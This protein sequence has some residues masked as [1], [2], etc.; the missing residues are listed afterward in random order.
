[1]D[2]VAADPDDPETGAR[3]DAALLQEATARFKQAEEAH[4]DDFEEARTIQEFVAL[5]QWPQAIKTERESMKRPC[6]T[7]DHQNQYVRHVVNTGL[8]G[9]RDIRVLALSGEADEKVGEILAG[10]VRQ[11]TQ[12][13]SSR[14]AYET[15]LRHECQFGYGY[16]QVKVVEVPKSTLREITIRKVRD[17]R[18][19][20]MDPFCDYPDGRDAKFQ[21]LLTKLTQAEL[22]AQYGPAAEGE[23][24]GSWHE[25]D[26]AQV[27][28]WLGEDGI[29]VAEYYYRETDGTV[30]FAVLSPDRVLQRGVHH[31]DVMPIVRCVGDE[32][33]LEGKARLR[34]LIN[35]SSMDAGRAYNYAS[36]AFIEAVALAPLAPIIAEEGQVEPYITEWKDAHRVP[37]AVLRYKG[38]SL[39]GQVLPPPQR[40]QP[41]GIPEG[42][43]GMMTNL[44][45][46]MQQIMGI[47]QPSVMGTGGA[48][49]QS[50]AGVNAQQEPGEINSF[51]F[52]EHWHTAI[53]QTGRIILA[54][55]P[56]VYTTAQAVKIVGDDLVPTTAILN[57]EQQQTMVESRDAY[58]KVLSSSYNV[59]IGR[60]D[61]AVTTG[62]SSASK[63]MEAN[64]LLMTVVNAFPEMMKVAGDLVVGSMDMAGA[65]VLAKR[66]KALLPPGTT[67]EETGQ[68]L[69]IQQLQEENA[70][71]KQGATEL[72][73]AVMA[74]REKS[75][76]DLMRAREQAQMEAQEH[77]LQQ[78]AEAFRQHLDDQSAVQ[79]ATIKS[80]TDLEIAAQSN[81]V[82]VMV[83]KIAAGSKIDVE[84]MKAFSAA[85]QAERHEDRMGGYLSSMNALTTDPSPT[86]EQEPLHV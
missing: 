73:Q 7:L 41:A 32:Y 75:Q 66:L 43:Q 21:F 44:I 83:A 49:V 79:L 76:A 82:K 1:M 60:Y 14:V 13:S 69:L 81:V 34:G 50:G 30:K 42:W 8:R 24:T 84:I 59:N 16:W 28:P 10:M 36:S 12:V 15:G 53:E 70:Q 40:A 72:Q 47:G 27:L 17:P 31:G 63:K 29:I 4:R 6:L 3:T 86:H 19:V 26:T 18:M 39:S 20:L 65:D 37:R 56:H 85:S 58:G 80:Q 64:K 38:V 46:D 77:E 78:R 45:G 35:K 74:E 55:I 57:P 23:Q 2:D 22:E 54:M 51:H 62:P 67:D 48:P 61:V 11:I 5:D 68:M 33:E 71:L 52:L 9:Q 25:F